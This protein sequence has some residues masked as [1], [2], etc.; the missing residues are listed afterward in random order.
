MCFVLH[1]Y[2]SIVSQYLHGSPNK[3][4]DQ[5]VGETAVSTLW[6]VTMMKQRALK[7]TINQA[8]GYFQETSI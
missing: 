4:M 6:E 3:P 1:F 5:K 2:S 7:K 8:I